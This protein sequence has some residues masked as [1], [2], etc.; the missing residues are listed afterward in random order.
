MNKTGKT[1]VS[2]AK[3]ERKLLRREVRK[4]R[5]EQLA[6]TTSAPK[7]AAIKVRETV[8]VKNKKKNKN[9]NNNGVSIA[10]LHA[11]TQYLTASDYR[12][13]VT[14]DRAVV[15]DANELL[16]EQMGSGP[17]TV[18]NHDLYFGPANSKMF[19]LFSHI[20][21]CFTKWQLVKAAIDYIELCYAAIGTSQS[22]GEIL[23]VINYDPQEP[24]FGAHKDGFAEAFNYTPR[25]VTVPFRNATLP[26]SKGKGL[27]KGHNFDNVYTI[28]PSYN[29]PTPTGVV[30]SVENY[31]L[32]RLQLM[33]NNNAVTTNVGRWQ[34][35]ATFR[36]TGLR[37][38]DD[39]LFALTS[40]M[41][42]EPVTGNMFAGLALVSGSADRYAFASITSNVLAVTGLR[43]G[44][45]YQITMVA[46]AATSITTNLPVTYASLTAENFQILDTESAVESGAT[47]T[48]KVLVLTVVA[49]SNTA[50]I[51]VTSPTVTGSCV[52]DIW[53][54][55]LPSA[56]VGDDLTTGVQAQVVAMNK[57]LQQ[58]SLLEERID[59][60]LAV[61]PDIA[62]DDDYVHTTMRRARSQ[63]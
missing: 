49:T 60:K 46:N 17:D 16:Y 36:M 57:K 59:R 62:D 1:T 45:K 40:H 4:A 52:A 55:Q 53:F 43:I 38:P 31:Y 35:R 10:R 29:Q 32:G 33:A 58:L 39:T 27:L 8:V 54:T 3:R 5:A 7:V 6:F 13:N 22:A 19:P 34:V 37:E 12:A 30:A 41:Q 18:T 14:H 50:S 42:C 63:K 56:L 26:V 15:L 25:V 11:P 61:L 47:T 51:T 20:A 23:G 48:T 2:V 9:K 21:R 28:F 44:S 24:A